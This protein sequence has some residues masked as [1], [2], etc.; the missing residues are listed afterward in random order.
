[1][2]A[3]PTLST[4]PIVGRRDPGE[5]ARCG[6]CRG[7][8][9]RRRGTGSSASTRQHGERQPIS[10]LNEPAGATV[11]AG[12]A[13][14]LG[15]QVLGAGLAGRAGD[16]DDGAAPG[17]RSTTRAGERGRARVWTS[18]TTTH[19]HALDGPGDQHGDR[20]GSTAA[21]ARSRGRRRARRRRRRTGRP[22]RTSRESMTTGPST[23]TASGRLRMP[24]D[25][26]PVSSAISARDRAITRVTP[27]RLTAARAA[28]ST[29]AVVERVHHAGDL[30]ALLVAL[31]GD[32]RRCRPARRSGDG[33]ARSAARRS[34]TST[35][36]GR[37]RR[38]GTAPR[39]RRA[40]RR[41]SRRGPRSAGCRR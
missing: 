17:S 21:G 33:R 32:Q 39:A 24:C 9:S 4:T 19:G 35:H 22:G 2:C 34:P 1:M 13:E 41:G 30:L 40:S 26:P 15:E 25:R 12:A 10:L 28:R 29:V 11:G 36:L 27:R 8:P 14:H 38:R 7:R 23:T 31:A 6:R 18:S 20:A 3:V 37:A 16:A 5:V